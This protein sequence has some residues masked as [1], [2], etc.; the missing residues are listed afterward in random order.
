MKVEKLYLTNVSFSTSNIF[1]LLKVHKSKQINEAIQRQNNEYIEIHEPDDLTVRPVVVGPNCPARPLS[2]LINIILK[3]FLIHIKSYVKDNLD[4]LRKCSR[5]NN[6]TTTYSFT[7]DMKSLYTS[8]S[9]DYGL[10]AISF[11][12]EKHPD[13]LHSRFSKG[14]VLESIKIILENNNCSFN[15]EFYRQIS[16]TAMGTIFAPHVPH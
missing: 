12:I 2:Q 4:F 8:I 13:S 3:P 16:G 11:W 14:F 10:E 1:G 7:F 5:K 15:D 9:H 6:D